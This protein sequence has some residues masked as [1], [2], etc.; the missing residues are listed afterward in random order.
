MQKSE[1]LALLEE[2]LSGLP[3][4]DA[5][6]RL[7]FYEE[8]IDDRVEEGFSEAEAVADIG[9][10][11]EV[12]L[13][14][15][16]ETPLLHIVKDKIKP[17][18]RLRTWEIVLLWVGSPIWLPLAIAAFAV[19]ISVYAVIWSVLISLWA[20][21]VSCIGCAVGGVVAGIVMICLANVPVGICLIAAGLVLAGLTIFAFLGCC[22]ASKGTVKLTR[23]I[24]IGVK[25]CFMRKESRE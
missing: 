16:A 2:K 24:A 22:A 20:V 23:L 21:F 7:A 11:D 5:R 12:V 3:R 1:F 6:E 9:S 10:V 17:R 13:Q 4:K 25:R 8:M 19:M 15:V 14:I 18:R